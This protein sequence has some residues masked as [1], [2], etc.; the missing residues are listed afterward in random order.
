MRS[1]Y[2]IRS[3]GQ[4]GLDG[5]QVV[6]RCNQ[7]ELERIPLPQLDQILVH[8]NLQLTTP[9]IRACLAR[10]VSIA[11]FSQSG[12]CQGRL[13]PIDKGYRNRMRHQQMLNLQERQ[14]A[15]MSLIRGKIA[16]CRVLL[17]RLTRRQRREEVSNALQRL[18]WLLGKIRGSITPERLRGLEGNA[19]LEYQRAL[20]VLLDENGFVIQGRQ[21]RPPTSPFDAL[22]S[23]G[24]GVLGASLQ[25]LLELHGLDPYEGVLHVGSARHPALVSDLIEPFRTLLVDPFNVWLIRTGRIKV[26]DAFEQRDG[27]VYLGDASRRLWMKA[28]AKHMA[29]EVQLASNRRGPRWELL[30]ELVRSFVRFV[31]DPTGGLTVPQRR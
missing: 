3:H 26:D 21:Y 5:E 15:A 27:G 28:W 18:G 13:H 8:G 7:E 9:L 1:L 12:W 30:D 24:Y 4:V 6:V 22:S 10:Q 11:F 16:N 25:T 2:L 31:Y 23:Y 17:L 19:A 20:G 29:E 14:V